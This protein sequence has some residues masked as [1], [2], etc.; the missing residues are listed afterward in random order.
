MIPIDER[1]AGEDTLRVGPPRLDALVEES[2]VRLV[3]FIV[4]ST[5]AGGVAPVAVAALY[6]DLAGDD[7]AVAYADQRFVLREIPPDWRDVEDRVVDLDETARRRSVDLAAA[8]RRA[9]AVA[10][11]TEDPLEQLA[12]LAGMPAGGRTAR[13][14]FDDPEDLDE[15]DEDD[16]HSRFAQLADR[17]PLLVDLAAPSQERLRRFAIEERLERG[18]PPIELLDLYRELDDQGDT[19]SRQYLDRVFV[20]REPPVDWLDLQQEAQKL[21]NLAD[22]RG[23][24]AGR[25]FADILR[26]S[27]GI[28]ARV[29]LQFA[30]E[31]LLLL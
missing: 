22:V 4:T 17:L 3:H 1:L 10:I 25:L 13:S 7:D 6:A 18:L 12:R 30:T 23:R 21:I 19:R 9:T 14:I 5:L 26:A 15:L 27:P 29:A 28:E 2:R 31:R 8:W 11:L 20:D 16:D 24:D